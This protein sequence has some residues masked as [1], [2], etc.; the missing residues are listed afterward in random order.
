MSSENDNKTKTIRCYE[1]VAK[2][3]MILA[4]ELSAEK[5][6]VVTT[7]DVIKELYNDYKIKSKNRK[8]AIKNSR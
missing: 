5:K 1:N 3:I 8:R 4:I 6:K 7:A 2:E